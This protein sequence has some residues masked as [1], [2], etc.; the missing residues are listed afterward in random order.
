MINT[1]FNY[2]GSKYKL[3]EQIIPN[4]DY[5][6]NTFV[7]LFAGGGSVYTNIVDKYDTVY[8]NDIIENLIGIHKELIDSDDIINRVKTLCP[9]KNDKEGFLKLRESYNNKKSP[10]KL[11]AL[12]LGCNSNLM[13][14]N[15]KGK[16][17]QTW[18]NRG[19]SNNTDKKIKLFIEHIRPYKNKIIFKSKD[20]YEIKIN[21]PSM[22]YIDPPYGSIIDTNGNISKKQISEAGYSNLWT[23]E[24]DIKLYDYIKKLNTNKSSFMLSGVLEHNDKISWLL[25]KLINDEFKYKELNFNYEKISKRKI[26]KNT[27]EIIIMNY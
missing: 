4:F 10:D 27:K 17:N 18:G 26:I 5:T 16:F 2:T 6:K 14:F 13:R 21:K 23:M 3:L 7:D 8:I 22:V 20:F 24:H 1:P 19:F 25:N 9:N 11:F 15:K 12:I